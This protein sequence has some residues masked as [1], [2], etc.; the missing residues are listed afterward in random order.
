[1][2]YGTRLLLCVLFA[3]CLVYSRVHFGLQ[4]NPDWSLTVGKGIG[5]WP[6]V[7]GRAFGSLGSWGFVSLS[8]LSLSISV[9]LVTRSFWG[10]VSLCSPLLLY[11]FYPGLDAPGTL[12][13]LLVVMGSRWAVY[14][15]PLV[16]AAI[17]PGI[18]LDRARTIGV[19][20]LPMLAAVVAGAIAILV[21][22]PYSGAVKA[23]GEPDAYVAAAWGLGAAVAMCAPAVVFSRG[24][25]WPFF[26]GGSLSC[27]LMNHVQFRYFL[28][29]LFASS[30][31][32]KGISVRWALDGLRQ[33]RE[34]GAT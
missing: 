12:C 1:M 14:L 23:L 29:A 16:H 24:K 34:R 26:L 30:Y 31:Q 18:V 32:A 3:A 33:S 10:L 7:I 9:F 8:V 21:L 11:A 15:A 19:A 20:A 28:P 25:A 13:V 6:S 5:L 27:L 2:R 4:L 22:T 17:L